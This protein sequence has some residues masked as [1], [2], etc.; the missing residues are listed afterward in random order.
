[1]EVIYEVQTPVVSHI[2]NQGAGFLAK[3]SQV[4]IRTKHINICHHSKRD[5]VEEN[6]IDIKYIRSKRNPVEIMTN[7]CSKVDHTRN[8]KRIMEGEIWEFMKTG[9]YNVLEMT[10][11][12]HIF[13][14]ADI[15][16]TMLSSDLVISRIRYV[17]GCQFGLV[18]FL[19]I[20]LDF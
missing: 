2:Y 15:R 13:R 6:N 16:N 1:M 5:M 11:S 18:T 4:G 17:H 14:F 20:K 9:G 7:T 19:I 12:R 10:A 8:S 3:T